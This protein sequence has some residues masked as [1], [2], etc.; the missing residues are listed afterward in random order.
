MAIAT[1]KSAVRLYEKKSM[2]QTDDLQADDAPF[3][4][5]SAPMIRLNVNAWLECGQFLCIWAI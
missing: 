5:H 2:G 3:M 1:Y 4:M